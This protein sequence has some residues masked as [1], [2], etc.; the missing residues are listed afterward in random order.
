[1]APLSLTYVKAGSK[2]QD[3][4]ANIEASAGALSPFRADNRDAGGPDAEHQRRKMAIPR[5]GKA[6]EIAGVVAWLA[7]AGG[8]FRHRRGI[9]HRRWRQHLMQ[10]G[11]LSVEQGFS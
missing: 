5:F 1:M 11:K 8:T 6:E 7:G 10:V 9:H 2:A 3:I 4:V